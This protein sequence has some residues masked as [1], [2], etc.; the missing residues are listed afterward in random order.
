MRNSV[1]H[2][3]T[4]LCVNVQLNRSNFDFNLKSS[5]MPFFHPALQFLLT[6]RWAYNLV[7][8]GGAYKWDF[9]VWV[10]KDTDKEPGWVAQWLV[11][12]LHGCRALG[13][14]CLTGQE[15]AQVQLPKTSTF[16]SWASENRSLVAQWASEISLSSLDSLSES[17]TLI[18]D[19]FQSETTSKLRLQDK[20]NNELKAWIYL[21]CK[22]D[23]ER[24]QA[25]M[26]LNSNKDT[27]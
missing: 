1:P 20:W 26:L 21:K 18:N 5:L 9:M 16:C 8:G 12:L 11:T 23:K 14:W 10:K 4:S 22:D 25:S 17:V 2:I 13:W 7:G 27:K 19:D 3:N 24:N 6:G 15:K